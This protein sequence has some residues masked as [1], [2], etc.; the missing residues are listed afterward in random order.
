MRSAR[1]LVNDFFRYRSSHL[2]ELLLLGPVGATDR[3]AP[4]RL[5]TV[6]PSHGGTYLPPAL[7]VPHAK[8]T[9]ARPGLCWPASTASARTLA[10]HRVDASAI[11]AD[12]T[13]CEFDPHRSYTRPMRPSANT[14]LLR[15]LAAIRGSRP[16]HQSPVTN[17]HPANERSIKQSAKTAPSRI[18]Q[19][20]ENEKTPGNNHSIKPRTEANRPHLRAL[21][22]SAVSGLGSSLRP[23]AQ[24]EMPTPPSIVTVCPVTMSAPSIRLI[25]SCDTSSG[26]H[27][28][29]S[30][31]RCDSAAF[32]AS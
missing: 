14:S 16:A 26:L 10:P 30:G 7:H 19:D 25:T 18:C 17:H 20:A 2:I 8:P 27:T 9:I 1:S 31:A 23:A 32:P 24:P 13:R 4:S 11:V 3:H 12:T 15:A 5:R 29:F 28:A 21:G 6:S 22:G